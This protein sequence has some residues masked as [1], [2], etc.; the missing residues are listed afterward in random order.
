[1]ADTDSSAGGGL[2]VKESIINIRQEFNYL[3]ELLLFGDISGEEYLE[4]LKAF[5]WVDE[6]GAPWTISP[7]NGNWYSFTEEGFLLGE[8]PEVLYRPVEP[9]AEEGVKA[10]GK[11][12]TGCGSPL[13]EGSRFCA[14]CGR[15][16]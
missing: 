2:F 12:C 13:G 1:M 11:F 6:S 8:P 9:L 5:V 4:K 15:A 7:V 3:T 16:S 14:E 10:G